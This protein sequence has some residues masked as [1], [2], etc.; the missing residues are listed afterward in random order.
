MIML[1]GV[2]V[3]Y[4]EGTSTL[5]NGFKLPHHGHSWAFQELWGK[6]LELN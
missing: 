6:L 3:G 2:S 4:K 5:G 1:I